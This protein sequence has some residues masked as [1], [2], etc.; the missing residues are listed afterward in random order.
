MNDGGGKNTLSNNTAVGD[1]AGGNIDK[2]TNI[3]P[4]STTHPLW[5]II[6][7]LTEADLQDPNFLPNS[8]QLKHYQNLVNPDDQRDLKRKLADAGRSDEIFEAEDLKEKFAKILAKNNLSENAQ[9]AY[10]HILSMIKTDY[11]G[12][13]KPLIK[14]NAPINEIDPKVLEIINEMYSILSRP[15]FKYDKRQIKGMLY[16]LTGNCHIDWRY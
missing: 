16:F 8:Q 6:E 5:Q 4:P 13:V 1:F 9:E 10:V 2:S 14:M 11:E 3:Y 12:K 15:P 7:H